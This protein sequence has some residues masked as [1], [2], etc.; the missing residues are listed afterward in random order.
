MARAGAIPPEMG[1]LLSLETLDLS[2]NDMTG[3]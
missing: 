3:E 1:Q 2:C